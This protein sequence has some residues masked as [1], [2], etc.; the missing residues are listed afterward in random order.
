MPQFRLDVISEKKFRVIRRI[1]VLSAAWLALVAIFGLVGCADATFGTYRGLPAP[2]RN[3][4]PYEVLGPATSSIGGD[5]FQMNIDGTIHFVVIEGIVAP[6]PGQA[7]FDEA[8]TQLKSLV[9]HQHLR[10]HVI[11]RDSQER[12][13]AFVFVAV[14]AV[15]G[16]VGSPTIDASKSTDPSSPK[17]ARAGEVDVGFEMIQ[18]GFS[19]FD[20]SDFERADQYREAEKAARVAPRGLWVHPNPVPPW[21]FD[22]VTK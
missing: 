13:V 3:D 2:L 10:L 9:D 20:G 12:E 17:S 18:R 8:I 22:T 15:A 16:E 14:P 5:Y 19:W 21:E 1:G 7:C 6:K 4:F 11:G